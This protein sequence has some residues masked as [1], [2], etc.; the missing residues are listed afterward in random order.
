MDET[1]IM[2]DFSM[3]RGQAR[4]IEPQNGVIYKWDSVQFFIFPWDLKSVTLSVDGTVFGTPQTFPTAT[5]HCKP[6]GYCRPPWGNTKFSFSFGFAGSAWGVSKLVWRCARRCRA[7]NIVCPPQS[8]K[9]SGTNTTFQLAAEWHDGTKFSQTYDFVV[10][11]DW[12]GEQYYGRS[13]LGRNANS[14]ALSVV[15]SY[16]DSWFVRGS[17]VDSN[18]LPQ[19]RQRSDGDQ[20]GKSRRHEHYCD[21]IA[22]S[23]A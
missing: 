11:Q 1:K 15:G 4:L 20:T 18:V 2:F 17:V 21:H 8:T 10:Q 7:L 23:G 13:E 14:G 19:L 16:W 22:H 5:G 9:A 6:E 3:Q 12:H